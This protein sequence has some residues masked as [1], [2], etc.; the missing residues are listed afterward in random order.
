MLLLLLLLSL[1]LLLFR[2]ARFFFFSFFSF[3]F[4][5]RP[6]ATGLPVEIYSRSISRVG[7]RGLFA[8]RWIIGLLG[9]WLL[10]IGLLVY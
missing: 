1:L 10:T 6:L 8:E 4:T 2:D 5:G 3:C 7:I 9:Y